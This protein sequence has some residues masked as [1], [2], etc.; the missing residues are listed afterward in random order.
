MHHTQVKKNHYDFLQYMDEFRWIS[1]YMQIKEVEELQPSNIM[2]VGIGSGIFGNLIK[3]L[4]YKYTSVDF[5]ET[6]TPDVVASVLDLPFEENTF[7][8]SVSFQVLEHLEYDSFVPALK[9]LRRVSKKN[10]VISLPDTRRVWMYNIYIPKFGNY[11]FNIP[12]PQ[13]RAQKHIWDGEHYWEIS[14]RGYPL[15]KIID[16]INKAG[17]NVIKTYKVQKNPFHRFF[18]LDVNKD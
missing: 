5:D 11:A 6:L 7:D 12:K 13:L 18:I 15:S 10:I 16:D 4:G 17:L 9:E 3:F 2:E 8:V 1:T 14:K